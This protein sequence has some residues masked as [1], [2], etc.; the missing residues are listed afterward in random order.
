MSVIQL[1]IENKPRGVTESQIRQVFGKSGQVVELIVQDTG[2]GVGPDD[3]PH[4]FTRFYRGT[5]VLPDRSVLRAPGMGQGLFIAKRVVEA[6]GGGIRLESRLG[7]GTRVVCALPL[8]SPVTMAVQ[9]PG[10][11]SGVMP[12]MSS[13]TDVLVSR[14]S[15]GEPQS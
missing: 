13:G 1:K 7:R 10:I 5:P 15:D 8:T 3:L 2:V 4:L 12:D 11:A 14:H 6:H 9:E